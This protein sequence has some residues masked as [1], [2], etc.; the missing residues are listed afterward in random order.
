MLAAFLLGA[1]S[2]TARPA[3]RTDLA[4]AK[5]AA[6]ARAEEGAGFAVRVLVVNATRVAA[7]PST[8][9]LLLSRDARRGAGDAVIA[10]A[11]TP[12]IRGKKSVNITI[13]V[14]A[15]A[16]VAAGTWRVLACADDLRKVAELREANNCTASRPIVI[17]PASD[18]EP[19]PDTDPDLDRTPT[20]ADPDPT[21][22]PDPDPDPAPPA[23]IRYPVTISAL[24]NGSEP[25]T[26]SGG[27]WVRFTVSVASGTGG[28]V[29][30]ETASGTATQGADFVAKSGTAAVAPGHPAQLDVL[31]VGD[32]L[33]EGSE[34]VRLLVTGSTGGLQLAPFEGLGSITDNDAARLLLA[35]GTAAS[36]LELQFN[37]PIDPASVTANGSQFAVTGG[38]VVTGASA[39]GS[40]VV[41][42]TSPQR[43]GVQY[44]VSYA[45]VLADPWGGAIPAD[46][47]PFHGG[48]PVALLRIS[49]VN[50]LIAYS[51]E[52]GDQI[53]LVALTSGSVAGQQIRVGNPGGAG[54]RALLLPAMDV[55]AGDVIVGHLWGSETTTTETTSKSSCV[56]AHCYPGAWDI[57]ADPGQG[58]ITDLA[59]AIYVET[60]EGQFSD[61]VPV[62]I[63]PTTGPNGYLSSYT[64]FLTRGLWVGPAC[65]A[66]PTCTYADLD[67][68]FAN[69][70]GIATTRA[71]A[72]LRRTAPTDTNSKADWAVGASTWGVVG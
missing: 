60:I 34:T 53:E 44:T 15:A 43:G 70:A 12:S 33:H 37:S 42:T 59:A 17:Q 46:S 7:T 35:D 32:T 67:V 22:D 66:A 31:L 68:S 1:S 72:S 27:S 52:G 3:A 29:T 36:T 14:S 2:A 8:T 64:S 49:E 48:G 55:A 69:A 5:V 9:R 62:A 4:A 51:V 61:F 20:G 24:Q 11:P 13:S 16:R 10:A 45:A 18:P 58:G 57:Q 54:G 30:Y 50:P 25:N 47:E 63:P 6:P 41:L 23:P 38:V 71:G 40:S 28:T 26:G 19:D 39:S 21:P 65:A 56:H